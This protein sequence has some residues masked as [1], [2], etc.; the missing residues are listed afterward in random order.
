[1]SRG[2]RERANGADLDRRI[3]ELIS[4]ALAPHLERGERRLDARDLRLGADPTP[5]WCAVR[6]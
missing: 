6:S 3:D 4:D 1:V 5:A 2:D